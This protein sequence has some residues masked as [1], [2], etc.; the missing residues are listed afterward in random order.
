M[1]STSRHAN[2][3]SFP[4][5]PGLLTPMPI[6]HSST[7]QT[8]Q[9]GS[10]TRSSR[11][12]SRTTAAHVAFLSSARLRPL[13]RCRSSSGRHTSISRLRRV[14]V[15]G[16]V[17]CTSGSPRQAGTGRSGLHMRCSRPNR[18][19]CPGTSARTRT[20]TETEAKATRRRNQRW[21]K[22]TW[23]WHVRC[24]RRATRTSRARV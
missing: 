5:I 18:S 23:S 8:P 10:S 22:A 19:N 11:R 24:S 17:R 16:H 12:S 21:S 6:F 4:R 13:Y 7:L 9:L 15:P 14:S 3:L 1:R 2:F 20:E